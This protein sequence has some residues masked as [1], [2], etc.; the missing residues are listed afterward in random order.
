VVL[1]R[2]AYVQFRNPTDTNN[3]A[4]RQTA[5]NDLAVSGRRLLYDDG[6]FQVWSPIGD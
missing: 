2:D 3:P 4:V 1:E 5:I 6:V